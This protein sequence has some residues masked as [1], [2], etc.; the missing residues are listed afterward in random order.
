MPSSNLEARGVDVR[1]GVGVAS[2]SAHEVRLTDG[3][4]VR[5]RT[6][7]ATAGTGAN[8]LLERM[9]LPIEHGRVRCDPFGRVQCQPDVFAAGDVAAIPDASGV[10]HPPT[11]G[12]AQLRGVTV[13]GRLAVLAGRLTFLRYMP[14][15]RRRIRLLIDWTTAGFLGR[16][17]T[18]MQVARSQ[19][20]LRM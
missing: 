8:P 9:G 15:W 11:V 1:V 2:A 7:V 13:G 5:T 6:L 17:V 16:D 4:A 19:A 12:I 18:Q 14:N 20:V 3:V 10:A